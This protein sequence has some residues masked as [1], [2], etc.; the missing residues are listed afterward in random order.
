[1]TVIIQCKK[2]MRFSKRKLFGKNDFVVHSVISILRI[3]NMNM[4]LNF[5]ISVQWNIR[6]IIT[7]WILRLEEFFEEFRNKC[8]LSSPEFSWDAMLKKAGV[9]LD[10]IR[11]IDTYQFIEKSLKKGDSYII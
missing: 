3:K 6:E 2:L 9:K 11:D 1:M 7:I 5:G 4:L 10:L 8:Y